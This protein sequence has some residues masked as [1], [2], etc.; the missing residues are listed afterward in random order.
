MARGRETG[1][2]MARS[3][4]TARSRARDQAS[5][6]AT[7]STTA[8]GWTR[9]QA[10][11]P[12]GGTDDGVDDGAGPSIAIG[13]RDRPSG[14]GVGTELIEGLEDEPDEAF[15]GLGIVTGAAFLHRHRKCVPQL[16]GSCTRCFSIGGHR[17]RPYPCALLVW[18]FPLTAAGATTMGLR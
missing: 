5:R 3:R 14:P 10:S 2:A 15:G 17:V 6:R 7:G 11:G 13:R 9:D 18:C 1:R 16:T 4:R 8:R 12:G